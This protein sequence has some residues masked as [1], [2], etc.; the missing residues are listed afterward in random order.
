M[1]Q[2]L[3][4]VLKRCAG[5][6]GLEFVSAKPNEMI[7]EDDGKEET[8]DKPPKRPRSLEPCASTSK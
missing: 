4:G 3:Q 7:E 1:R 6:L 2:K 5:S 8:V